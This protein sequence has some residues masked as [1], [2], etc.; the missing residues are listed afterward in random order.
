MLGSTA[1]AQKVA[2]EE[3]D[4]DNGLHVVLHQDNSAPVIITSVM[5]HVG[6]KDEQPNRTGFAH[7]FEHYKDLEKGKWVKIDGWYG[8]DVAKE[9]ILGG[10]AAYKEDLSRKNGK[11]NGPG[12]DDVTDAAEARK[13]GGEAAPAPAGAAGDALPLGYVDVKVCAVSEVWSGLKLVVRKQLRG[14][15]A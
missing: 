3:F 1:N 14:G 8:P 6:A 2:F 12:A 5:Y 10:V 11:Y 7:F 9:E 13:R 4:L 15:A